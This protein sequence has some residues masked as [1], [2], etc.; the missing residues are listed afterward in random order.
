MRQLAHELNSL[1]DGAMRS[2]RL[3]R[4][5]IAEG[6][7]HGA[8]ADRLHAAERALSAMAAL[9]ARAMCG[10]DR[11]EVFSEGRSLTDAVADA[12]E[13]VTAIA[14]EYGVS[15]ESRISP[16][17]ASL[18]AGPLAPVVLNGLRNAIAAC[19]AAGAG[20]GAGAEAGA[21]QLH[22]ELAADVNARH[23][24]VITIAD[25]GTG[26]A[27]DRKAAR[28]IAGHGIG[29]DLCRDIM[30]S[31]GGTIELADAPFGRGAVLRV[32]VAAAALLKQEER[33]AA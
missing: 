31:L 13:S 2:V 7:A 27:T 12:L 4:G 17:A 14:D 30:E 26:L 8:A 15:V 9:L 3:A 32:S 1:L 10:G 21:P 25:S 33:D 23:M 24:L 19:A 22:V 28:V 18:P 16:A 20:A 29:L 5:S 11:R 6:E